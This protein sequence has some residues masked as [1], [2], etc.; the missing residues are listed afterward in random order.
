MEHKVKPAVKALIK[1]NGKILVLKTETE[2]NHYW[3]LPG[4][5]IEYGEPPEESLEREL[6][7]EISCTA[8]IGNPVGMYHFFVGEKNE[9]NQVTLTVFQAEIGDQKIDLSS[10]PADENITEY[11]WMKPEELIEKT[12]NDSLAE[13]VKKHFN[14]L[15]K[16]VRDKIPQIIRENNE[17]SKTQILTD[18]EILDWVLEKIVEEADELKNNPSAGELADLLEIVDRFKSLSNIDENEIE[19]IR[20][21]KAEKR[22]KFEKNIV[23]EDIDPK[24]T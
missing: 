6:E 17:K 15:P 11:R 1:R 16:L 8:E 19:N 2:N 10:N 4:G 20:R 24:D 14:D 18:G 21:S 12:D 9:G 23:L 13:L 5:K 3:V 22:G 7:E